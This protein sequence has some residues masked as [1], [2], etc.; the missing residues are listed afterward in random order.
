M[1]PLRFSNLNDL[2][3]LPWFDVDH[4]RLVIADQ[5]VGDIID[6]HTHIALSYLRVGA[7]DATD[8][9]IKETSLYLPACD[10][11][12]LEVYANRNISPKRMKAMNRDIVI[13]SFTGKGMR[14]TH[15]THNL[16]RDMQAIGVRHAV[17][18]PIELPLTSHNTKANLD[19]V[20]G[21]DFFVPFGSVHPLRKK[22]RVLL[23][24]QIHRGIHGI[25]L[26][27]NIQSI[28]PS[29]KST[30]R[31]LENCADRG[32]PVLMHCGPVDI[33][34]EPALQRYF[35]QVRHFEE[36]LKRFPHLKFI[37]GHSGA[38]Q[39]KEALRLQKSYANAYLDVSCLGLAAVERIVREADPDRIIFGSDWPFYHP[40]MPL[41]KV[42]IATE[43]LPKI[44]AKILRDNA[45]RLFAL[46]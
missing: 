15:T 6:C 1:L 27:P 41:A 25:K 35:S 43:G 11:I 28:M 39:S 9:S 34:G 2:A 3:R 13:G 24:E 5:K 23:E 10:A 8:D 45:K 36:P 20:E 44:R 33:P 29:A 26:H 46:D 22:H 31:V 32:V 14:K 7:V 18:L 16:K 40:A 4:N 19:A 17:V 21:D 42:L 12:D 30:L 37:L 38:L